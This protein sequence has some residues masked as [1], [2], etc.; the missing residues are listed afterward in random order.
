MKSITATIIL[1]NVLTVVGHG[2]DFWFGW[3]YR[4][5]SIILKSN[6]L[7]SSMSIVACLLLGGIAGA[8]S[9]FIT[10]LRI[11]TIYY[12]DKYNKKL[13]GFFAIFCVA[14]LFTL[15]DWSG[16]YVILLLISNYCSFIP[17]WFSKDTQTIRIGA[18]FANICYLP[19]CVLIKN[20]AAIPM[21]VFN[22]VTICINYVK[23]C[24]N[25]KRKAQAELVDG[26]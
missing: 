16:W 3:K 17:K 10:I 11:I 1:A 5:K 21:I 9:S 8:I 22:I 26:K 12:K 15:S 23:W 4:E 20:Y 14:Y 19:Y 25:D 2:L 24:L 13:Y 7:T 6:V 18:F